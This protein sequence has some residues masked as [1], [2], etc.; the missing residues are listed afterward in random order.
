MQAIEKVHF[1]RRLE[2]VSKAI[3][4]A[5]QN[6]NPPCYCHQLGQKK[7]PVPIFWGG[8]STYCSQMGF[9]WHGTFQ[10]PAPKLLH[11][12]LGTVGWKVHGTFQATLAAF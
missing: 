9:L 5:S 7:E 6:K 12:Y 10:K 1:F 4:A 3:G 11:S 8:V 2:E